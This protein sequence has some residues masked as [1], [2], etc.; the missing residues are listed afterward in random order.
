ME[1]VRVFLAGDVM[2]GCGIDQFLPHAGV[3]QVHEEYM[4]DARE[5]VRL[6]ERTN[7][8]IARPVPPTHPS[9]DLLD[10]IGARAARGS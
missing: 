3:P 8:P 5:C 6:A 10:E 7:G 4:R 9:S 1:T 2:T